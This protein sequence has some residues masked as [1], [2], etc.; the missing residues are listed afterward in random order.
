MVCSRILVILVLRPDRDND[1]NRHGY[2]LSGFHG[3]ADGS[4]CVEEE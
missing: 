3:P 4:L 1:R 2:C